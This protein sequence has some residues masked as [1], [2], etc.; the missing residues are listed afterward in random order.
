MPGYDF[1]PASV[2]GTMGG[3][4]L[5]TLRAH[6]GM[7]TLPLE[8]DAVRAKA[9][10]AG[11]QAAGM[12]MFAGFGIAMGVVGLVSTFRQLN[13]AGKEW[14]RVQREMRIAFGA[15]TKD[16]KVLRQVAMDTKTEFSQLTVGK[17]LTQLG[18]GGYDATKSILFLPAAL[19]LATVAGGDAIQTLDVLTQTMKAMRRPFWEVRDTADLLAVAETKT[20]FG[21]EQMASVFGKILPLA[22]AYNKSLG[23][24]ISYLDFLE[25][26][27]IEGGRAVMALGIL[28]GKAGDLA[29]SMGMKSTDLLDV[30]DELKTR[31]KTPA[32]IVDMFGG[33]RQ[34]AIVASI[35]GMTDAIREQRK[36]LEDYAGTSAR[37]AKE[38]R[39][40]VG[41]RTKMLGSAVVNVFSEGAFGRYRKAFADMIKDLTKWVTDNGAMV[42]YMVGQ[43]VG[44]LIL[45][46]RVLGRVLEFL[47]GPMMSGLSFFKRMREE[48]RK[49][50]D[51]IAEDR[52]RMAGEPLPVPSL[53]GWNKFYA[54]LEIV[55]GNVIRILEWMTTLVNALFWASYETMDK[56][57]KKFRGDLFSLKDIPKDILDFSKKVHGVRSLFKELFAPSPES[58][59]D[60]GWLGDI[61]RDT[62]GQAFKAIDEETQKVRGTFERRGAGD[63]FDLR[64]GLPKKLKDLEAYIGL[65]EDFRKKYIQTTAFDV[66]APW[67]EKPDEDMPDLKAW[68][69]R[70]AELYDQLLNEENR[71]AKDRLAVWEDFARVRKQQLEQEQKDL[72]E[73][74]ASPKLLKQVRDM[75]NREA[76]A[77]YNEMFSRWSGGAGGAGGTGAWG[78]AGI[79]MG[80]VPDLSGEVAA[81]EEILNGVV[82]KTEKSRDALL[83]VW[84]AYRSKRLEQ[85]FA[86]RDASIKAGVSAE[87]AT[88]LSW[89]RMQDLANQQRELFDE[90]GV[91]MRAWATSVAEDMK[92][93]MGDVFFKGM[94]EGFEGMIGA[95]ESM[96][97]QFLGRLAELLADR[98]WE[99]MGMD[100][101]VGWLEKTFSLGGGS[102]SG[103][104]SSG[105][106]LGGDTPG[107]YVSSTGGAAAPKTPAPPS[108]SMDFRFQNWLMPS[109]SVGGV[110]VPEATIPLSRLRDSRF[111]DRLMS[112]AGAGAGTTTPVQVIQHI[113]TPDV[114]SFSASK[115]QIYAQAASALV[116]ASRRFA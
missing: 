107:P 72:A 49:A 23:E 92:F 64:L 79:G 24:M 81:L 50:A 51:Q 91:W 62:Y 4:D 29:R 56:V 114:K 33:G 3:V 109:F 52:A 70:Q 16:M 89:K 44:G 99:K 5:G 100:R 7:D 69:D 94:T 90:Q 111:Q 11:V 93:A 101:I 98:M 84:M 31:G 88:Q 85:I 15:T 12:K 80:I 96:W 65:L 42:A 13:V 74:G 60:S 102:G 34:A 41:A 97:N 19:D 45:L 2:S 6:I 112:S 40:G 25:E 30:L 113:Q 63:I 68:V 9:L 108:K 1:S 36:E 48:S 28:F 110:A 55:V 76:Q 73:S 66:E 87:T 53:E 32:Q 38:I 57:S 35:Y 18:R 58:E 46:T 61:I 82:E 86:E 47:L 22:H 83:K 116:V 103:S 106:V 10:F 8:R 43:I 27:G 37:V 26:R 78:V 104:V 105:A 95:L 67:D 54:N 115:S 59:S 39:S 71:T 77:R 14:A 75:R 21:A 17:V 20:H